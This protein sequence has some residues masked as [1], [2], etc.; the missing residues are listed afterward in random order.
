M[1]VK[2]NNFNKSPKACRLNEME[3]LE[4]NHIAYHKNEQI[5]RNYTEIKDGKKAQ[6]VWHGMARGQTSHL[7]EWF[8]DEKMASKKEREIF[9]IPHISLYVPIWYTTYRY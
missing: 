1:H 7:A 2:E 9:C 5:S 3:I 8:R 6:Y 4:S